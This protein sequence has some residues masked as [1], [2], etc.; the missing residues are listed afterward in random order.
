MV[1][2]FEYSAFKHD[3]PRKDIVYVLL[4]PTYTG[5]LSRDS[6]TSR[7]TLYIGF[8]HEQTERELEILVRHYYDGRDSRIFHVNY[9][10]SKFDDFRRE[11]PNGMVE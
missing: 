1:P 10:T 6:E 11:Y 4:H 9:L 8:Q 3:I 5:K 2:V 7:V